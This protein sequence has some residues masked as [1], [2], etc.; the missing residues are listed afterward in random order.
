MRGS[1]STANASAASS[2][3]DRDQF[4]QIKRIL[5]TRIDSVVRSL[6]DSTPPFHEKHQAG[7][8]VFFVTFPSQQSLFDF[9]TTDKNNIPLIISPFKWSN[10]NDELVTKTKLD[11]KNGLIE[12]RSS[13]YTCMII[14]TPQ[15]YVSFS[16]FDL[17]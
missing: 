14:S 13:N 16:S 5:D 9:L 2:N 4:N 12:A 1:A 11:W 10:F 6:I 8:R 7:C 15:Q 17:G 3:N